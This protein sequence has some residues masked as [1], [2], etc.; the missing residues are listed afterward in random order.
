MLVV[1]DSTAITTLLKVG[2]VQL[3]QQLFTRLVI[4]AAV[5]EELLCFHPLLP[6]FCEVRIVASSP[7]LQR[8]LAQADIGEA[9][10]ISLAVQLGAEALLIDDKKGRRLAEAEGLRCLGLPAV[11]LAARRQGVVPSLARLL[12]QVAGAGR[13]RLTDQARSSLLHAAGE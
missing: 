11:L 5:A 8:L 7:R 12:E 6:D 3:L 1:S 2:Q 9:H 10:A 13:Y 4:P